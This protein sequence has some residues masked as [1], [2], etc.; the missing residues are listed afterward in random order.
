[1]GFL[2]VAAR[3]LSSVDLDRIGVIGHS[4]GAHAALTYGSLPG[5][6][7]DAVVSL[8]TTQDYHGLKD[9]GWADMT[10][11]VVK[12]RD[13]FTSPLLMVAG[14]NA[15]FELVDT[16]QHARRYYFTIKD[17]GHGDYIAHGI[18]GR[19]RLYQLHL[20]DPKLTAE[21]KA[22]EK[23]ALAT[24]KLCYHALCLYILRFLEAQLKRDAAARDFLTKQYRDTKLGG[25]EPH[26]EFVTAGC[27]G[28]DPY[29]ENSAV[30]P[31]PRQL[32]RFLRE[33]GS[34]KTIRVLKRFRRDSPDAP[35]YYKTFELY[36]VCDLLDEGKILDAILFRDYYRE[37]GLHFEKYLLESA[38]VFHRRGA[39]WLATTYYKRLLLFEPTNHEA[40]DGLKELGKEKKER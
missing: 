30:P 25:D 38:K 14:P 20:G 31:T 3:R 34:G 11:L 12:N 40:A 18:I 27:T 10:N 32:H 7:V 26:V 24:V 22:E 37:S 28:P 13:H 23:V 17:M 15:F 35:I 2:V 39:T 4:G 29:A 1:M 8:D 9:P 5:A 16:L 6:A 33:E 19:E 21:A 36:M